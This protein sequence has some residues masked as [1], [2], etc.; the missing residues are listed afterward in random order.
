LGGTADQE[1]CNF[2]YARQCCEA[3]PKEAEVDAV[4]F[5]TLDGSVIFILERDYM[6]VRYGN[7]DML[8]GALARQAEVFRQWPS[9]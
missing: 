7:A 3:F 5:T 1:A 8:E 6:P 4:R 2:G 9:Q